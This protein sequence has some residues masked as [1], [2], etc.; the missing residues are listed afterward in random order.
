MLFLLAWGVLF[1]V[2]VPSSGYACSCV[3]PP[4]VQQALAEADAVFAGK[5]MNIIEPKPNVLGLMSSADPVTVT[6]QVSQIWKGISD[7]QVSITTA[8][9]SASCG[10]SFAE[11][12]EYIVYAYQ[13]DAYMLET[14]IC[15]RTSE[16]TAAAEDLDVLGKGQPLRQEVEPPAPGTQPEEGVDQAGWYTSP[17]IWWIAFVALGALVFFLFRR[18]RA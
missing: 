6:F 13:N 4:A 14:N 18:K 9:S 12:R 15:M 7:K 17:Y 2:V 5:V 10:Y 3:Q 8:L 1:T 11:D 16:L